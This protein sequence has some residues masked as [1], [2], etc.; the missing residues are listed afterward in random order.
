MS[1]TGPASYPGVDFINM[2]TRADPKSKEKNYGFTVSFCAF[3]ICMRVKVAREN[4]VKLTPGARQVKVML[5]SSIGRP[6]KRNMHVMLGLYKRSLQF[7]VL[8]IHI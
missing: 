1:L 3:W 5:P 2:F 6:N 7:A 4:L 8:T